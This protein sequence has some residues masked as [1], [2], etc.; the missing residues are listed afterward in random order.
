MIFLSYEVC[1][2]EGGIYPCIGGL[3]EKCPLLATAFEH[4]VACIGD[5]MRCLGRF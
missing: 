3:N 5:V 1:V 2:C 4:L